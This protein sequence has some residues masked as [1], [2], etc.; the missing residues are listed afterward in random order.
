MGHTDVKRIKELPKCED[1]IIND[2]ISSQKIYKIK[3]YFFLLL[4]I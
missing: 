3:K 1:T 2:C 4:Y